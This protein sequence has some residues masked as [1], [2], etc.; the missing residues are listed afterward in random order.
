M[1]KTS[2]SSVALLPECSS[3][4]P[5]SLFCETHTPWADLMQSF[6]LLKGSVSSTSHACWL[7][8][9]QINSLLFAPAVPSLLLSCWH[10]LCLWWRHVPRSHLELSAGL[11]GMSW[12]HIWVLA[13]IANK[14]HTHLGQQALMTAFKTNFHLNLQ[15]WIY[16][17]S[18]E[19][20]F[21][22]TFSSSEFFQ[23]LKLQGFCA[24]NF[25]GSIKI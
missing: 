15:N 9:L 13:T 4:K 7:K 22:W 18:G 8:H 21:L 25:S 5:T 24:S 10:Q 6:F 20:K 11:L 19:V 12:T 14:G 3:S 23:L 17:Y 1:Q 2:Q 16:M